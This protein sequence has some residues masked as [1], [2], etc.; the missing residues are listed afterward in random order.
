MRLIILL[1]CLSGCMS[2]K[3]H[4][5]EIQSVKR[6]WRSRIDLMDVKLR[7]KE[8]K[9]L[10][11]KEAYD[12]LEEDYSES[13]R[14]LLEKEGIV[15]QHAKVIEELRKKLEEASLKID[16]LLAKVEVNKE[17]V[18]DV[19]KKSEEET[20]YL[21]SNASDI[22]GLETFKGDNI[23]CDEKDIGC[24]AEA[25]AG[26]KMFKKVMID[27]LHKQRGFM[28]DGEIEVFRKSLLKRGKNKKHVACSDLSGYLSA[29]RTSLSSLD[30]RHSYDDSINREHW[31]FRSGEHVVRNKKVWEQLQ[32]G[33]SICLEF[34]VKSIRTN[35]KTWSGIRKS[36]NVYASPVRAWIVKTNGQTYPL[37][38]KI[39]KVM[40][41]TKHAKSN[42]CCNHEMRIIHRSLDR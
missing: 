7:N 10:V 18:E 33:R 39:Y 14:E 22:N 34:I 24:Y 38:G 6:S 12:S 32:L 37:K 5:S 26:K 28:S 9:Y 2:V 16:S 29:G 25:L 35:Y 42:K 36:I 15:D 31:R 20:G 40:F 4:E 13:K 21:Y 23:V 27:R 30:F 3:Q 11:L 1:I 41:T 19:G 8:E 17:V